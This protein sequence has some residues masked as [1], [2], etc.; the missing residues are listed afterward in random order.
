MFFDSLQ[1]FTKFC[2]E[3]VK[4][5]KVFRKIADIYITKRDLYKGIGKWESI[6]HIR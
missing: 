1:K 6:L 4:N 5:F 2:K 3:L